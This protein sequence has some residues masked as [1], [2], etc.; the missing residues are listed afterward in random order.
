MNEATQPAGRNALAFLD[1]SGASMSTACAVHC[2]LTPALLAIFP[3]VGF[4]FLADERTELAL[5]ALSATLGIASLSA[6][7]CVHRSGRA[8]AV[9]AVGLSLLIAGRAAEGWEHETIGAALIAGGGLTLAASHLVNRR[10][11]R[12]AGAGSPADAP[13]LGGPR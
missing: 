3:L 7:Y 10:C 1:A 8:L 13:G 6:G 12:S 4:G 5:L 11:C 2:A 9:L